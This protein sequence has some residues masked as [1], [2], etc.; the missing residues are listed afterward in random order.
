M[1]LSIK[2]RAVLTVSVVLAAAAGGAHA[3]RLEDV[4]KRGTVRCGILAS[5]AGQSELDD[6]GRWR[7]FSID[8]CRGLAA[9]VFNDPGKVEFRPAPIPQLLTALKSGD[10]DVVA[11]TLTR[12][13]SREVELGYVFVGPTIY[14]GLTFMVPK[15]AGVTS[16]KG[17]NGA[18]ICLG[19]GS[20]AEEIVPQYM[21]ARKIGFTP[22]ATSSTQQTYGLYDSKRCD[23][24]TGDRMTLEARKL[25]RPDPSGHVILSESYGK[26]ETGPVV[27]AGDAAWANVAQYTHYAMVTAEELGI[28]QANVD[29]MRNS[30]SSEVRRFIGL[31]GKL[32]SKLG[33]R[34]DFAA[35]IVKA[36]GN[37]AEVWDRNL[38]SQSPTKS[39][40]EVNKPV[41]DGGLLSAPLWR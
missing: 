33:L 19:T 3:G 26:S 11:A 25:E 15:S 39:P 5:S 40:R 12:T 2:W 37:Y 10:L 13:M 38:G 9:A 22:L 30:P 41:P 4:Q 27:R 29:E 32:G 1:A 20:L 7:G 16:I 23:A 6:K 35:A 18:T 21:R 34:D 14:T 17:L 24:V 28:T 36:T 8:Y 31:E